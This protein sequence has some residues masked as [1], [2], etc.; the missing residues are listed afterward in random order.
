MMLH[1][2]FYCKIRRFN[3][4]ST[5]VVKNIPSVLL[6]LFLLLPQQIVILLIVCLSATVDILF[7]LHFL[8]LLFIYVK[9]KTC[10]ENVKLLY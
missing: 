5:V 3:V 6:D 10:F 9:N 4:M 8:K 2:S 7:D 1:M